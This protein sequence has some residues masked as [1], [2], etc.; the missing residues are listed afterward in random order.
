MLCDGC[1]TVLSWFGISI[2]SKLV[3]KLMGED[4]LVAIGELETL[5]VLLAMRIWAADIPSSRVIFFIDNEGAKFALIKG[6]SSSTAISHLCALTTSSLDVILVLPWFSRVPSS[7]NIADAPSR[8]RRDSMLPECR[9]K[10]PELVQASL[11]EC[12][13]CFEKFA[14][15]RL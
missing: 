7:S 1:G 10:C 14:F 9:M 8:G 3:R 2:P 12:L 4:Q 6:Y 11:E 5:A 15:L 13:T